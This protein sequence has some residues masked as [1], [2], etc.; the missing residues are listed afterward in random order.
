M[1]RP[2]KIPEK[3]AKRK[4]K[5]RTKGRKEGGEHSIWRKGTVFCGRGGKK[6]QNGSE[7]G[8][9]EHFLGSSSMR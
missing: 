4:E 1:R 9:L 5:K 2:T 7:G 8:H 3:T 6:A